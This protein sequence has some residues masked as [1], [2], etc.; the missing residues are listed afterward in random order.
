[1]I[2]FNDYVKDL[3]L[4]GRDIKRM[5]IVDNS[6][7]AFAFQKSNGIL[8]KAFDGSDDTDCVLENLEKIIE[9]ILSKDYDDIRKELEKRK[10]I[11]YSQV[12]MNE[13]QKDI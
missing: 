10:E 3:N 5:V 2:L 6:E 4:L 7:K 1:M 12:T 8:I 13:T 11:I 9:E